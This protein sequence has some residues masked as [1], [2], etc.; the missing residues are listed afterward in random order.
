LKNEV[1]KVKFARDAFTISRHPSIKDGLGFQ[2]GTKNTKSQRSSTLQRR[3]GRHLWL[4]ACILFIK[5]KTML[6]CILMSR[7]LLLLLIMIL[8]MIVLLFP[9][10][11]M[12][13]LLL[14]LFLLLLVILIGIELGAMLPMLFLMRLGIGMHLMDLLFY[15][16]LLMPPM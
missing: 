7:M 1:E 9:S 6:I 12:V 15:F 13:F 14:A 2:K 8:V 3:R 10:V 5:R 4:V 16:A 11:M